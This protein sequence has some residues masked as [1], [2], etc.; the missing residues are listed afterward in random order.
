MSLELIRQGSA[1][2]LRWTPT[3]GRGNL[4]IENRK[5]NIEI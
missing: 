4:N 1:L 5:T 2:S 3:T